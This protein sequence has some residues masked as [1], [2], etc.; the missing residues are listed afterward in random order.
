[1]RH[2][3]YIGKEGYG[4]PASIFAGDRLNDER[5]AGGSGRHYLVKIEPNLIRILDDEEDRLRFIARVDGQVLHLDIQSHLFRD[6]HR[7]QS[8]DLFI[9]KLFPQALAY[10]KRHHTHIIGKLDVYMAPVEEEG[11]HGDVV[12][13]PN[14]NYRAFGN[15]IGW[16]IAADDDT[17]ERAARQTWSGRATLAQ[18]FRYH[19][20]VIIPGSPTLSRIQ[21]YWTNGRR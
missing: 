17:R 13:C 7:I 4:I 14:D 1:M 3:E 15:A 12:F 9:G 21:V 8:S 18:G 10:F 6:D 2:P 20:S 19:S 16:N 11:W 5:I